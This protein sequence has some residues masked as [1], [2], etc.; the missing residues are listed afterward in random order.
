MLK[1]IILYFVY[2]MLIAAT[3]Y[4]YTSIYTGAQIDAVVGGNLGAGVVNYTE[5]NADVIAAL[6]AASFVTPFVVSGYF[7]PTLVEGMSELKA[8]P[9]SPVAGQ[10]YSF[11]PGTG[12]FTS[13]VSIYKARWN[14]ESWVLMEDALGNTYKYPSGVSLVA[15]SAV[16][17][18]PTAEQLQTGHIWITSLTGVE[19]WVV[20]D[21]MTGTTFYEFEI[22]INNATPVHVGTTTCDVDFRLS[23]GTDLTSGKTIT[24]TGP[25][26]M[27]FNG[28]K[29][30]ATTFYKVRN[31]D[32]PDPGSLASGTT[33]TTKAD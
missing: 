8:T 9:G 1:K 16:T 33:I 13:G 12:P 3:V 27:K 18:T 25:G 2:L 20:L 17:I 5:L 10:D 11:A 21:P 6:S 32:P 19:T 22:H 23:A 26:A 24:Q 28:F 29:S 30:G 4:A 15:A 14:G 31:S 7:P